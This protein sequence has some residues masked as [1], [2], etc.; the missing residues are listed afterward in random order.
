M[1]VALGIG[2]ETLLSSCVICEMYEMMRCTRVVRHKHCPVAA[3]GCVHNRFL[4]VNPTYPFVDL[5]PHRT[6]QPRPSNFFF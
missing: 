5:Q 6:I 1:G 4:W 3:C 2:H